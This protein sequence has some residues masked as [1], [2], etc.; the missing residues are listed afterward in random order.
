MPKTLFGDV[1]MDGRIDITDAVLLNKMAAGAVEA[2]QSQRL[3]GDVNGNGEIDS[4]D[5]LVLFMFVIQQINTLPYQAE[6]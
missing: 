4:A 3:N 5:G 2:S 6:I 1:N